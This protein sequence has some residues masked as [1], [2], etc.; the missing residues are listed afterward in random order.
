M[1]FHL[2]KKFEK[3]NFLSDYTLHH[4]VT[5]SIFTPHLSLNITFHHFCNFSSMHYF[6]K[7]KVIDLDVQ[8]PCT[9]VYLQIQVCDVLFTNVYQVLCIEM[10]LVFTGQKF[11]C[12]CFDYFR[13]KFRNGAARLFVHLFNCIFFQ[14]LNDLYCNVFVEMLCYDRRDDSYFI[15]VLT[16]LIVMKLI[17]K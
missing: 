1:G 7:Q 12:S 3:N 8:Y 9:C 13:S 5:V 15:S 17:T 4:S 14:F 6:L 11:F 10:L 2:G 16:F